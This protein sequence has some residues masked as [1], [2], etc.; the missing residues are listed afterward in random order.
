MNKN[1]TLIALVILV[2]LSACHRY[3][4]SGSFEEKS[5]KHKQIAVLPPRMV[6]TGNQPRNLSP[7][8]IARL[9]ET[10]SKLF[11][12]ALYNNIL[13]KGN[14]GKYELGV[15]VQ[16]YAN[17]LALLDK[18][19]ISV[20]ESW[21]KS[22]GELADALGVDAVVRTT[23]QKDRI[24]SDVASATIFSAKKILDVVVSRN[25]PVTPG[26]TKTA[27]IKA[28][29]SLV[30]NGETL[31]TDSYNKESDFSKPANEVI[32]NITNNFAKHFPYRRKG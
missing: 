1:S 4:T 12:E 16:P 29:C 26:F 14:Q 9:E 6:L 19:Q 2:T 10:E 20:R 31:W 30:S 5:S 18:K 3:Y 27:N 8:D 28:T 32:D 17:T 21:D 11:Q 25:P 23:I 22:D 24:M 13:K 15:Q 7:S